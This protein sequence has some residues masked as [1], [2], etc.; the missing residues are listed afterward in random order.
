MR[1]P[2]GVNGPPEGGEAL[3][4]NLWFAVQRQRALFDW[5]LE[6]RARRI[7]PRTRRLLWWAL[8]EL[9]ELSGLPAAVT[10]SLAAG[11]IRENA[12][13]QEAA[14]VNGFLRSLLRE[15]PDGA[16]LRS[17]AQTKAPLSVRLGL[18][19][20]LCRHWI[21]LF[22][23]AETRRMAEVLQLPAP[24]TARKRGC[25]A[26]G[27]MG[28]PY[29]KG[30]VLEIS[31][32]EFPPDIYYMQ[33]ASTLMAPFLMQPQPGETLA[34]LCASPGGKSLIL[35]EAV[36]A[37]GKLFCRDRAPERLPHLRE[38]LEKFPWVD[39]A[40]G[41]A[42]APDLPENSCDGVLLDVPCSNSGVIRR[43]PDVRWHFTLKGLHDIAALQRKILEGTAPLLKQGGRIIYSTCSI[44]PE[45]NELQ[46]EKFLSR[47]PEF[48]LECQHRLMPTAGHDGA[49]AARLRKI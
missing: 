14:F 33:D 26:G 28:A 44:D 7:R 6:S 45:E 42:S 31:E 10:V 16:A 25:F 47:H 18:P 43:R 1:L 19:E 41:D 34:D 24:V 17:L 23:E 15:A 11:W 37:K 49:F 21:E 40:A 35:A 2:E 46:V 5:L 38:N 32:G 13:R 8:A 36:G 39:I 12:S 27:K 22:G 3:L 30:G 9:Y 29:P 48:K 20:H 4:K